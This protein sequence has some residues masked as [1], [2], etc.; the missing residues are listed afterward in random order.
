MEESEARDQEV[1]N[2]EGTDEDDEDETWQE[3]CRKILAK[4]RIGL[5]DMTELKHVD[6]H[7][8]AEN[9]KIRLAEEQIYVSLSKEGRRFQYHVRLIAFLH[10]TMVIDRC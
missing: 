6:D 8:I 4:E 2:L 3:T 7:A 5:D 10:K 9:L 1:K